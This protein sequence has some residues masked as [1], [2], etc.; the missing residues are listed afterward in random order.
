MNE[1]LYREFERVCTLF[2][3]DLDRFVQAS[4]AEVKP[5]L[6]DDLRRLTPLAQDEYGKRDPVF[7]K[8]LRNR[9]P[10]VDVSHALWDRLI[11]DCHFAETLLDQLDSHP[12]AKRIVEEFRQKARTAVDAIDAAGYGAMAMDEFNRS[13][14]CRESLATVPL[15]R[16][17]AAIFPNGDSHPRRGI[18]GSHY[19]WRHAMVRKKSRQSGRLQALSP[20]PSGGHRFT[21]VMRLFLTTTAEAAIM[22]ASGIGVGLTKPA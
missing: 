10:P 7:L 15:K 17:V 19:F 2:F 14:E 1:E 9:L 3:E 5:M 13:S 12:V 16:V 4:E 21:R 20:V 11:W 6:F 8:Q 18:C 22:M